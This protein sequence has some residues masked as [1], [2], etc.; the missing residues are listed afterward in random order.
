MP[1]QVTCASALP[2]KM[3]KH[4]NCIFHSA[5]AEFNQ[6]LL[7]FFSVFDS[8]LILT[9]LNDSLNFVINAF[10]SGLLSGMVQE[11][12]SQVESAAAVGLC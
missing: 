12:G 11:K 2:G 10:S 5:L 8:Q 4:E 1:R 3:R 7:D 6:L 9:L